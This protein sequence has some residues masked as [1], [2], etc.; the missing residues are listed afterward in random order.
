MNKVFLLLFFQ[1]KKFFLPFT[2]AR[3]DLRG[4][5]AGLRIVLACLALGVAAIAA[6]GSLRAAVAEGL[7]R[8]GAKI[9]GGDIAISGG[10]QP[11]PVA[12]GAWLRERGARTSEVVTL[13]S[14]LIAPSGDRVLVEVKAVDG[15]WPLIGRAEV[16]PARS[17]AAAL[18]GGGLLVE[19]VLRDRMGL[20]PG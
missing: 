17:M 19:P 4:G 9:L 11:L 14:M 1:K 3:R 8:D 12:L 16:A 13:R 20:K 6:V 15:A 7:A 2:F 18:A 5:L 10:N